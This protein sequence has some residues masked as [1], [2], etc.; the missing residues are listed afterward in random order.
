MVTLESSRSK[1]LK[2]ALTIA[3]EVLG[4]KD[5]PGF[6]QTVQDSPRDDWHVTETLN[7]EWLASN[8]DEDDERHMYLS[9]EYAMDICKCYTHW[10]RPSI[11][12]TIRG[13]VD[14][15]KRIPGFGDDW[16]FVDYFAGVGLSSI[17][18]AQQL[19][20]AGINA[21]VIYHNSANNVKQVTLAE[22]FMSEFGPTPNLST[23]LTSDI[24]AAD[25]YL[26]YEVFEHMRKP[27]EFTNALIEKRN[28]KAFVHVSRFN[29]P[30]VSG[31]FP[32]YEFDG[33]SYS[34][35]AATKVFGQR[36]AKAN[37]VRVSVPCEFNGIPNILFRRDIIPQDIGIP[38]S[39]SRWNLKEE[40]RLARASQIVSV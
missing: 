23:H 34:G 35:K 33:V 15:R 38:A 29:L 39:R 12:S 6:D 2:H 30:K 37:Y 21:K 24:P 19:T 31:H 16:T 11:N 3:G 40:V 10:T 13:L 18:L 1:V 25:C 9:A 22:R 20:A 26:F 17:Y 4:I 5:Q 32:S 7:R 27:W 8:L 28:P 36:M 14:I